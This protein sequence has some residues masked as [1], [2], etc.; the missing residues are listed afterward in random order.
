MRDSIHFAL[1]IDAAD[2]ILDRTHVSAGIDIT[3][4]CSMHPFMKQPLLVRT[5]TGKE[6]FVEIQSLELCTLLIIVY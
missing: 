3:N 5:D 6:R 2:L 4:P 1:A